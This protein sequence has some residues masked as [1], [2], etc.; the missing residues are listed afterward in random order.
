MCHNKAAQEVLK[1]P[2]STPKLAINGRSSASGTPRSWLAGV[3]PLACTTGWSPQAGAA[4]PMPLQ[5][6]RGSLREGARA[7]PGLRRDPSV[8]AG[9]GLSGAGAGL[10][11][12]QAVQPVHQLHVVDL[13]PHLGAAPPVGQQHHHTLRDS[14]SQHPNS[15]RVEIADTLQVKCHGSLIATR[16]MR[17]SWSRG[18]ARP[19]PRQQLERHGVCIKLEGMAP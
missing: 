8:A 10:G 17:C 19:E 13:V 11:A 9:R 12:L 16:H 18:G 2:V 5:S 4:C 14:K 7:E 1:R 15:Y 3:V 6:G